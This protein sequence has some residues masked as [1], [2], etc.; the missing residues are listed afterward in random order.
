MVTPKPRSDAGLA[1]L[2][3]VEI[4][5]ILEKAFAEHEAGA[6]KADDLL[7]GPDFATLFAEVD[8]VMEKDARPYTFRFTGRIFH[9][10]LWTER[11]LNYFV[12]VVR[13]TA[14]SVWFVRVGHV[15]EME[16]SPGLGAHGEEWPEL[17]EV[18]PALRAD[19]RS[20]RVDR[21]QKTVFNAATGPEPEFKVRGVSYKPWD[22]KAKGFDWRR[23]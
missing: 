12:L 23:E 9:A 11:L 22:G 6:G 16:D 17:E 2:S 14:A 19:P 7:E 15:R 21:G 10:Q 8:R 18:A 5:A 1:R 3:A 4:D 13:E 20:L